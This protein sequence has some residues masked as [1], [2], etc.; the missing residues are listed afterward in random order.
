[1]VDMSHDSDVLT[2][3]GD[4]PVAVLLTLVL[5]RGTAYG[6]DMVVVLVV[7]RDKDTWRWMDERPKYRFISD[8][9]RVATGL[10]PILTS[11]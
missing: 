4:E 11:R 8:P 9:K 7:D 1:M 10:T 5:A 3:S 2:V 6:L